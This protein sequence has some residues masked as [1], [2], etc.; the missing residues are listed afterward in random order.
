PSVTKTAVAE[1]AK[2]I[3]TSALA[4]ARRIHAPS[5]VRNARGALGSTLMPAMQSGRHTGARVQ[6][7][8]LGAAV[9]KREANRRTRRR[10]ARPNAPASGPSASVAAIVR[11]SSS[12]FRGVTS[13]ICTSARRRTSAMKPPP[14]PAI[15]PR[16]GIREP[17]ACRTA[18]QKPRDRHSILPISSTTMSRTPGP[19]EHALDLAEERLHGIGPGE[20]GEADLAQVVEGAGVVLEAGRELAVEEAITARDPLAQRGHAR[21]RVRPLGEVVAEESAAL[22]EGP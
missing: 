4:T 14:W 12:R 19:G 15:V 3:H 9:L 7:R 8:H 1:A 20:T 11:G 13:R 16:T 22:D 6:H 5:A 18:S 21:V 10:H 2:A 17:S